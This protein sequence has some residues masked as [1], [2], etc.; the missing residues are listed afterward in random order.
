MRPRYL[1]FASYLMAV[2]CLALIGALAFHVRV[3]DMSGAEAVYEYLVRNE[4]SSFTEDQMKKVSAG[5]RWS[6]ERYSDIQNDERLLL[7]YSAGLL[8]M[9]AYFLAMVRY[10]R[11]EEPNQPPEP[12]RTAVTPPADAGD[13]ASG[14]H[15]S[16]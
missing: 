15:G 13:R 10:F 2:I 8:A 14:A 11:K 4:P 12:M 9:T 3:Q 1:V 6:H 16:S 7:W 5:V